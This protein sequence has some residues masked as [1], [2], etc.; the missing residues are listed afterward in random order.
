MLA[1][2][3]TKIGTEHLKKEEYE[4][5]L[6]N[7]LKA[8]DLGDFYA[9]YNIA[10]MYYFGDGVA[11]NDTQALKWYEKASQAGDAEASSN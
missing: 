8:S 1:T 3:Y 10:C 2:E 7:Y 4:K 9:M 11:K 6:E 5:A